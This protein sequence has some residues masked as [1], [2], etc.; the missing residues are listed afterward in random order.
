[1]AAYTYLDLSTGHLPER[2]CSELNSFEGVT[3]YQYEYGWFLVVP[4]IADHEPSDF[5]DVPPEVMALWEYARSLGANL[6]QLDGDASSDP[7][8]PY[9]EW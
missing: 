5:D 9:W 7:N 2:V 1:M 3:A 6:I 4:A 8:L